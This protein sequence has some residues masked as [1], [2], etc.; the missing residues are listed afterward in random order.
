MAWRWPLFSSV[1]S[2]DGLQQQLFLRQVVFSS[3]LLKC[4]PEGRGETR[5]Q[6]SWVQ[7]IQDDG[8]SPFPASGHEDVH[9][10]IDTQ[11]I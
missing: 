11:N 9:E 10:V 2:V 8:L 6:M 4:L 5:K 1:E 3:M 7:G